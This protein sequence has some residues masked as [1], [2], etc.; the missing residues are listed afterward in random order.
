MNHVD[1]YKR[2][3]HER[4]SSKMG[5]E[6]FQ[7]L[8][9][10]SLVD[11]LAHVLCFSGD[12]WLPPCEKD[13]FVFGDANVIQKPK[14]LVLVKLIDHKYDILLRQKRCSVSRPATCNYGPY[15]NEFVLRYHCWCV[16]HFV[17][18]AGFRGH[19][20]AQVIVS[21]VSSKRLS[22]FCMEFDQNE[23]RTK[24]EIHKGKQ[25][26]ECPTFELEYE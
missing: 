12:L 10:D 19:V 14:S 17:L 15:S 2:H 24:N 21:S 5:V 22:L 6:A 11:E 20:S 13:P 23:K 18:W 7:K 16:F 4:M 26:Y 25:L 1:F 3:D 9:T 8:G